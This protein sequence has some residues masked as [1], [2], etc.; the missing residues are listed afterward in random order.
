MTKPNPDVTCKDTTWLV[1]DSRERELT[2]QEKADL[3]GHI[4]TCEFCQ[5]A[6]KQFEVLFKELELYFEKDPAN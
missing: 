2:D 3:A 4:A 6:S 1:S 5:G